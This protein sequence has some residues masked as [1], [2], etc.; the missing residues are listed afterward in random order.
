MSD[1]NSLSFSILLPSAAPWFRYLPLYGFSHV[2]L[3][4]CKVILHILIS[5]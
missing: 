2:S 4:V 5:G 1:V 3:S